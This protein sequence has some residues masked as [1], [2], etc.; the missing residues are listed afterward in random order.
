MDPTRFGQTALLL[1]L[2]LSAPVALAVLT[3]GLL[4]SV[5]QAATQIQEQSL[6][7]VPRLCIAYLVLALTA[8][9]ALAALVAFLRQAFVCMAGV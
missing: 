8:A 4:V 9:S 5:L 3:V 2:Q 6:G 7:T 1:A